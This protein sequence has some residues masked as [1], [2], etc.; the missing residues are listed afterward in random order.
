MCAMLYT[1]LRLPG[2]V[3]YLERIRKEIIKDRYYREI[4]YN[5]LRAFY[6][7]T[8]LN[9]KE[10]TRIEGLIADL[11]LEGDIKSRAFKKSWVMGEF[12]KKRQLVSNTSAE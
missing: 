3:N 4:L 8:K 6:L 12:R 5:K 9:R 10:A 2:Y 7:M 1:D 11:A